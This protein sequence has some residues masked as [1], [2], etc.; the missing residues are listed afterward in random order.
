MSIIHLLRPCLGAWS[1]AVLV[2]LGLSLPLHGDTPFTD[3][4][5][6]DAG[7]LGASGAGGVR[8]LAV[9]D[10]EIFAGGDFTTAGDAPAHRVARWSGWEWSPLG[11][12]LDGQ[13]NALAIS[14]GNLYAGGQFT[15]AGGTAA[16]HVARWDGSQWSALGGGTNGWV[17]ALAVWNGQLYA[18]GGFTMAGGVPANFI[19]RWNGSSWSAVGGGLNGWVNALTVW[20]GNL[21]AGG[22]F[23]LGPQMAR[24]AKWDGSSWTAVPG[25]DNAVT[26]LL[27]TD[28][29]LYAGGAFAFAV[30]GGETARSIAKW[31]GSGWSALG[32]GLDGA[33]FAL[34]STPDGAL[35]AGGS[36]THAGGAPASRIARWLDGAWT[37]LGS[38]TDATVYSLGISGHGLYA[39]GPFTTAGGKPFRY[40]A[41]THQTSLP[42]TITFPPLADVPFTQGTTLDLSGLATSSSGR[43]VTYSLDAAT[44][45]GGRA[46][47]D[48]S[49]S[50]LTFLGPGRITVTASESGEPGTVA[51]PVTRT[52]DAYLEANDGGPA[53]LVVTPRWFFDDVSPDDPVGTLRAEIDGEPGGSWSYSLVGGNGDDDNAS[54]RTEVGTAALLADATFDHDIQQTHS[55][56]VRA[57]HSA[58][59]VMHGTLEL[60]VIDAS[61]SAVFEERN[62]F[63]SAPGHVNAVFQLRHLDGE[64]LN[65]P[66]ELF[67][68]ETGIFQ[69]KEDGGTISARESF[70]QVGKIE[71]VP[72]IV[73]TVLLLDNSSSLGTK[74]L[75]VRQAAK[76]FV[77]NLPAGREVAVYSFSGNLVQR[78]DFTSDPGLLAEAIDS[79]TLGSATT[80]LNGSI[81]DALDLWT[82]DYSPHGI[83]TGFLVVFTDGS[84]TTGRAT[85][86]EAI[87]KRDAEKKKIFTIGLG[88]EI[89]PASLAALG[90][91]GSQILAGGGELAEAFES[92]QRQI[93]NELNSY[94]WVN[95]ASPKRGDLTRTLT[96]SLAGNTYTE[97]GHVLEAEFSSAGFADPERGVA[98]D[99]SPAHPA[100]VAEVVVEPDSSRTVRAFTILPLGEEAPEYSWSIGDG[101]LADLVTVEADGSRVR[102]DA[103]SA[104]GTTTLTVTDLANHAAAL[105]LGLD[106]TTFARTITLVV[107]ELPEEPAP[108]FVSF[109][110]LPDLA[111]AAGSTVNLAAFSSSGLPVVYEVVSGPATVDGTTLTILGPG[112]IEL[113]ANQEGNGVYAPAPPVERSF[114]VSIDASFYFKG[115][116]IMDP[117]W[118]TAVFR[119]RDTNTFE[120]IN[121]P[122]ELFDRGIQIFDVEEDG[123]PL[124][125]RESFLQV[126]KIDDA[127]AVVR[128]V[129]MLDNSSS[130][131]PE[132]LADLREAAKACVSK[133]A[134]W[135]EV[136]IY[137]FSGGSTLI[138]DFTNDVE[139]LTSA[140]DGIQVGQATTDLYGGASDALD[141]WNEVFSHDWVETGFLVIVTDGMDTSRRIELEDLIEKR[142]GEGT[143]ENLGV[144][145][146]KSIFAI[147]IGPDV[148]PEAL[149]N[150]A[151]AGSILVDSTADLDGAFEELGR[152]IHNELHS[153]YWL[154]YASP[155]RDYESPGDGSPDGRDRT[156]TVK[157]NG[158]VNGTFAELMYSTDGFSDVPRGVAVDRTP[159]A[160]EGVAEVVLGADDSRTV[161]AFTI[162]PFAVEPPSYQWSLGDPSLATLSPLAADGSR[163]RLETAGLTGVTTLTVTDVANQAAAIAHGM[164]SST[165]TRTIT[166]AVGMRLNAPIPWA[167]G[168]KLLSFSGTPGKSYTLQTSGDLSTW[169]DQQTF[170]LPNHEHGIIDEAPPAQRFYRVREE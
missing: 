27:G 129:M 63:T 61:P 89:D 161:R 120:G 36:F 128:T 48:D 162:L 103:G 144:F 151:N 163:V 108:Q 18:G 146:E 94:Y 99:R 147:G 55:I 109:P 165:F 41:R 134:P 102:I 100:G 98:I 21:Y 154:N 46:V 84:D 164:P 35:F 77:A 95:Y 93:E 137:T 44:L 105:A 131:G 148:D 115:G 156:L 13:V 158:N 145:S 111:Y 34:A 125:P 143:E 69:V 101:A 53:S 92:V 141:R 124:S 91:A 12:G 121:L 135:H 65:L 73:R 113:R 2:A 153:I 127:S 155:R 42:P 14:G 87:G 23:V 78:Q 70:L 38:G 114:E 118:L 64:G 57:E 58:G 28:H 106:A 157:L 139:L 32:E 116:F 85:Q 123:V 79:I 66:A 122:R 7:A 112:R 88:P 96:I 160:P 17:N 76:D 75:A 62:V 43:P 97:D 168:T 15:T 4:D 166:L 26:A 8:A 30:S 167:G 81:L 82:E 159:S 29:G 52:F 90:N 31:N 11:S 33:A 138:R 133:L 149:G 10:S 152:R 50:V 104:E 83:S 74:L 54:F 86:A 107:G 19:A 130:L 47:L 56:R 59:D 16:P 51:L 1:G 110:A 6:R 170:F 9:G 60:N 40:L 80:D 140:I 24:L 3:D 5:W 136:A 49:T 37:P 150:L 68:R 22:S 71:N 20:N 126:G 117:S 119:L 25:P 169:E 72:S 132:G 45:A 67:E 142:D 39:G